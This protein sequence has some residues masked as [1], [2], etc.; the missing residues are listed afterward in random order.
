MLGVLLVQS[1]IHRAPTRPGLQRGFVWIS[2]WAVPLGYLVAEHPLDK[3]GIYVLELSSFQLDLIRTLVSDV[4]VLLN[5]SPDHIE[6]H[7]DFSNYIASKTRIFS[8]RASTQTSVIGI[9]DDVC[10]RIHAEL[11]GRRGRQIVAVSVQR[12]IAGGVYVKDGILID[13]TEKKATEVV[14]LTKIR[15]LLGVHNWQ[16][17]AAAYAAVRS[18]GVLTAAEWSRLFCKHLDHHLLQFGV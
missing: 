15:S 18:L 10:R 7:G 12:R 14:D 3:D 4:A 11:A 1:R 8:R 17:A 2:A 16:N 6:R 5:I 13:D 9:D